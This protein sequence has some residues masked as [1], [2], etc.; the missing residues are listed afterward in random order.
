MYTTTSRKSN[1]NNGW[2][3]K[4]L[5]NFS[6]GL[7]KSALGMQFGS[8]ALVSFIHGD[9]DRLNFAINDRTIMSSRLLLG[10]CW[11]F[12]LRFRILLNVSNTGSRSYFKWKDFAFEMISCQSLKRQWRDGTL[13][14]IR[15][16]LHSAQRARYELNEFP[17]LFDENKYM[18]ASMLHC[19]HLCHS[20]MRMNTAN[21]SATA[22]RTIF[23]FNQNAPS[24]VPRIYSLK[25]KKLIIIW[26]VVIIPMH[27]PTIRV[28]LIKFLIY[29]PFSCFH[30]Y[31]TKT[32][33]ID[34][35]PLH[36][37]LGIIM[38]T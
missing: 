29:T 2:K 26:F 30:I 21:G 22:F 24:H 25:L 16:H 7:Q 6:P 27:V 23:W 11:K 31:K 9:S 4:M 36:T 1:L 28:C 32:R 17:S 35:V 34:S 8:F 33:C 13:R 10:L 14:F 12:M 19:S 37:V 38:E 18:W 5:C 15:L 3:F 20:L